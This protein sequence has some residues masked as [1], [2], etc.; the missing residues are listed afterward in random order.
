[1]HSTAWDFC[2]FGIKIGH[3]N[4]SLKA[5]EQTVNIPDELTAVLR[6]CH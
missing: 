3:C 2:V 6:F 5:R 4:L 1:M